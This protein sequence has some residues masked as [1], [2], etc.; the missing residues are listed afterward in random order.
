MAATA[1][2]VGG[3]LVP[4]GIYESYDAGHS[5]T[6]LAEADEVVTQIT[7][8]QGV[9]SVATANGLARYRAGGLAGLAL[10]P[11]GRARTLSQ[12]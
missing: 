6:Q 4:W 12:T 7:I 1:Y 11:T 5:W 8:N 10:G 3:Q 9:I 2:G